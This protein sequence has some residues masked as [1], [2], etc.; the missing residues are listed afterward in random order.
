MRLNEL[1]VKLSYAIRGER[2]I[3][4]TKR[5]VGD[6]FGSEGNDALN[7]PMTRNPI[8]PSFY[9]GSGGGRGSL[10]HLSIVRVPAHLPLMGEISFPNQ[11]RT[12]TASSSQ[13]EDTHS[14]Q[15]TLV[16]IPDAFFLFNPPGSWG[17]NRVLCHA[18]LLTLLSL[19][20]SILRNVD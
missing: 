4:C 5:D 17:G 13:R 11:V 19:T 15:C 7:L 9:P 18:S 16:A 1:W 12:T 3:L 10:C 20:I 6:G 8:S 2:A 14:P